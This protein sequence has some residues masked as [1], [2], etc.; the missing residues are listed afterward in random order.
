MYSLEHVQVFMEECIKEEERDGCLGDHE[1]LDHKDSQSS[2]HS[3]MACGLGGCC[4][5]KV[6]PVL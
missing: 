4:T 6:D 1:E 3:I 5:G 2:I